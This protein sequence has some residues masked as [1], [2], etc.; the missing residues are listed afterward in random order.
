[1]RNDEISQAIGSLATLHHELTSKGFSDSDAA[2][3]IKDL[4]EIIAAKIGKEM[5]ERGPEADFQSVTQMVSQE[6][7][8]N[9]LRAIEEPT[10]PELRL[11]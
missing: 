2:G 10:S 11:A 4:R 8:S 7:L 9:Y 5:S 1:M 3:Q 6:V